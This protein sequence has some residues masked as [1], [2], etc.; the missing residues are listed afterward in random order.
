[1]K[2]GYSYWNIYISNIKIAI[3]LKRTFVSSGMGETTWLIS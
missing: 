3:D 2:E 1:M